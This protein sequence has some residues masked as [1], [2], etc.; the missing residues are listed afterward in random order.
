V[1]VVMHLNRLTDPVH[2]VS[3]PSCMA[4]LTTA[5]R[6]GDVHQDGRREAHNEEQREE[7][8]DEIHNPKHVT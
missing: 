4:W 5:V 6:E 3:G 7:E 2:Q 1:D 8:G